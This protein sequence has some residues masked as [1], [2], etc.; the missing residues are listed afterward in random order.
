MR[1]GH[2]RRRERARGNE[3]AGMPGFQSYVELLTCLDMA[4]QVN[5]LHKE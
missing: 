5:A 4:D 3:L 1:P 2:T